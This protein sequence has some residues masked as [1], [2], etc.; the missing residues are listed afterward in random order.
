MAK[1]K[2]IETPEKLWSYWQEYKDSVGVVC[3]PVTHPK[4]GVVHLEVPSPIHEQGFNVFMQER[5]EMGNNTIHKYFINESGAYED[6]R[7]T[8]T[9]IKDDKFQ[10][11][12]KYSAVGLH[13][14]KLTMSLL[15]L[16][17]KQEQKQ[18]SVIT[19][20]VVVVKPNSTGI[21]FA[22]RETDVN[23]GD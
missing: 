11:N 18:T 8:I 23:T 15:G 21:P 20:K 22:N 7:T 6:Y 2:Y 4:M 14:E 3:V 13:K 1:N 10:H 17:E 12:Y 9:R 19:G 5:Y 16:A